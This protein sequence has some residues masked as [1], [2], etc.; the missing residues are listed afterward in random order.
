[1]AH[2]YDKIVEHLRAAFSEMQAA[3]LRDAVAKGGVGEILLAHHLGQTL[4]NSD[5]G[6]DGVGA[7]GKRYEYKVSITDQYNF[8]FGTRSTSDTPEMKVRRHFSG[9]EGAYCARREGANFIEI[10]YVPSAALVS[11]LVAHFAGTEGA[12]IN[13]N[14]RLQ[15]LLCLPGAARLT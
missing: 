9:V 8:H 4:H 15:S 1:M 13:K 10:V 3:N 6:S 14:Y 7:D 2:P 12:Q 11:D 5:K